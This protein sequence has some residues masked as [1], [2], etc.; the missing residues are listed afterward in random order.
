MVDLSLHLISCTFTQINEDQ[1]YALVEYVTHL[2][3]KDYDATL[4]DLITLG[5]I[6]PR[7]GADP[8]KARLVV[9]LLAKV[10][11]TISYLML[12]KA[13]GV[14]LVVSNSQMHRQQDGR[15]FVRVLLTYYVQHVVHS[16]ACFC[17]H[18]C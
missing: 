9:P 3:A 17:N 8:E 13:V 12:C 15:S 10:R 1:R 2:I 18:I 7:V 6:D 4:G 5:F 16:Y 11:I 14:W